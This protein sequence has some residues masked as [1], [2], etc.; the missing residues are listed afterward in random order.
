LE[1]EFGS[2]IKQQDMV[3]HGCKT[4]AGD[5]EIVLAEPVRFRLSEGFYLKKWCT[6]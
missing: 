2:Q 3:V 4:R 6:G 5:A 1:H